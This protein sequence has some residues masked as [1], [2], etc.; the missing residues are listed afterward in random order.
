MP[1]VLHLS[2]DPP[3]DLFEVLAYLAP[4]AIAG[5]ESVTDDD[6]YLRSIR[7]DGRSGYIAVRQAPDG[8]GLEV[9]GP[10]GLSPAVARAI[11]RLFD[12]DTDPRPIA[13]HLARDP[14]LSPFVLGRPA[15]RLIGALDGFELAVRAVLGQAVT[16]RG[17]S[18]LTSRLIAF[19]AEPMDSP[20]PGLSRMPLTA[21]R[22]ADAPLERLRAI[23]IPRARAECL[24][25]LARAVAAG[26]LPELATD[27][28]GSD[29]EAFVTRF[30]ALPG[31][32][33]WTAHYVALRA[34]GWSD[35][36]PDSD[37]GLRRAMAN[38]SPARLRAAAEAWRPY[39]AYAARYLWT[40]SHSTPIGTAL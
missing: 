9:A 26:G 1:E 31:I 24:L 30:T 25:A 38:R 18:L 39:R 29:P 27:T 15:L 28:P 36:F 23:G 4:R 10:A 33:A 21:E 19:L 40:A 35:A 11:R 22:L 3:L 32:G 5:V 13:A 14:A 7:L 12:L 6:R 8:S 34:L 16:V 17:A 20:P 2:C 37:L